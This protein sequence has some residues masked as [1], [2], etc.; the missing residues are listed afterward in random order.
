MMMSYFQPMTQMTP[1]YAYLLATT[2]TTMLFLEAV[3]KYYTQFELARLGMH[4]K[5]SLSQLIFRKVSS[6][7]IEKFLF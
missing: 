4:I 3:V 2:F 5:I 1:L 7:F 6:D